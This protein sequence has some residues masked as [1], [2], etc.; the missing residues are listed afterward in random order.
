[1]ESLEKKIKGG[2]KGKSL[3][4]KVSGLLYIDEKF[5]LNTFQKLGIKDV[6]FTNTYMI[7][8]GSL[9]AGVLFSLFYS[10]LTGQYE[11]ASLIMIGM[12]FLSLYMFVIWSYRDVTLSIRSEKASIG[13][14]AVGWINTILIL[15]ITI[16]MLEIAKN[17]PWV[18]YYIVS[19]SG[20]EPITFGPIVIPWLYLKIISLVFSSLVAF[21]LSVHFDVKRSIK[22]T[23]TY[24]KRNANVS[25]IIYAKEEF[26]KKTDN[27]IN[28]KVLVF[29]VLFGVA[30]IPYSAEGFT[31]ILPAGLLFIVPCVLVFLIFFM[32]G[33]FMK[34]DITEPFL[35]ESIKKCPQCGYINLESANYCVNCKTE[36][37][38]KQV[39]FPETVECANCGSINSSESKFCKDC[40]TEIKK[41]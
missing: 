31:N 2:A 10:N 21:S 25:T 20:T 37:I 27:R 1:M 30:L 11:A 14:A 35:L 19:Q 9:I 12:I 24:V 28:F 38:S 36:I 6:G 22:E 17:I 23:T 41:T 18:D 33:Y 5:A 7:A 29:L 15:I 16:M 3:K 32:I 40:G 13:R 34:L 4:D 39:L 26:I 8:L